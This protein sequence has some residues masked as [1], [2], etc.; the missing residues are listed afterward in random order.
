M[1]RLLWIDMEMSGLDIER[2]VI[3]EVAVIVTDFNM[4]ELARYHSVVRQPQEYLDR[5][6]D[7]NTKHHKE[8]GLTDL[9]PSGKS[10]DQV[11]A[12]LMQILD[13]FFLN[14]RAVLAGNSIMQDRLFLNKYFPRFAARLHYRMVDVTSFKIIFGTRYGVA[15]QK[16]NTHRAVDDITESIAELK[17]YLSYVHA[18]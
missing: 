17:H 16:K 6:D 8:S 2:E 11:E 7:W 18:P 12:D 14:E 3:L 15:H 1:E 9:V 4:E 10:P 13:G 5:M